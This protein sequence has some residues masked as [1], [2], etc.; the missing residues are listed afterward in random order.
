MQKKHSKHHHGSFT[1]R[2]NAVVI[3][4]RN[5]KA[6]P[7]LIVHT[8]KQK[9]LS[10]FLECSECIDGLFSYVSSRLHITQPST[11]QEQFLSRS[12]HLICCLAEVKGSLKHMYAVSPVR[13]LVD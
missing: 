3:V 5:S 10:T 13:S 6:M 7:A 9:S 12:L 11:P 2:I 1:N 4:I 8:L